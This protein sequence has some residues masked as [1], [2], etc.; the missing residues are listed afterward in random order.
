MLLT[1]IGVIVLII[2]ATFFMAGWLGRF[3]TWDDEDDFH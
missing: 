2:A 3:G 1:L